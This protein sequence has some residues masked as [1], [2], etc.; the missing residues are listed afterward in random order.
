MRLTTKGEYGVRAVVNLASRKGDRPTPISQIAKE[1]A[2]SQA[3]LEQIFYRLRKTGMIRSVRGPGGGF[4]LNRDPAK[5]SLKEILDAVGEPL[6]PVPCTDHNRETCKRRL[7]CNM[8]P[9]WHDFYDSMR[10][11]LDG[12]TIADVLRSAAS[13]GLERDPKA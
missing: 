9:F 3:F 4:L 11:H 7:I 1:E 8:S 12:I 2:V 5:V 10:D 6:F 13:R